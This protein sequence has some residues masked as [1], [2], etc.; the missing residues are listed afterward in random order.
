MNSQRPFCSYQT[1]GIEKLFASL[2]VALGVAVLGTGGQ[3]IQDQLYGP[4]LGGKEMMIGALSLGFGLLHA[5][6]IYCSHDLKLRQ[7]YIRATACI[8]LGFAWIYLAGPLHKAGAVTCGV[9]A[10]WCILT[11]YMLGKKM[12]MLDRYA[13]LS[14]YRE[15]ERKIIRLEAE[16]DTWAPGQY[17]APISPGGARPLIPTYQFLLSDHSPQ[18][19]R[20]AMQGLVQGGIL[21]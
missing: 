15:L 5:Y 10:Y 9:F 11:S 4:V 7:I 12:Q 16:M 17:R 20:A 21:P 19:F 2:Y 1:E 6:A 18:E 13:I 14:F 3:L 8:W